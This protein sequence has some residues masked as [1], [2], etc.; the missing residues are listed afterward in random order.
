MATGYILS[1]AETALRL[2]YMNKIYLLPLF[3]VGLINFLPLMGII[4]IEKIN[5]TYGLSV[6]DK[7]LEILLRHRAFLFGLIGGFV[8]YSLFAPQYQTAAMVL[9][10]LSMVSFILLFWSIGGSNMELVK[11][12]KADLVAVIL[13]FV[14]IL[15][16]HFLNDN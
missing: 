14:A 9:A 16:K 2:I 11:I 12:Y 8:F 1:M 6:S 4:S 3:L 7:N 13:L 5:Q 15:L 10:M